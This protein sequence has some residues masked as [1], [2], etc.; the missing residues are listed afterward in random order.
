MYIAS[1]AAYFEG[2]VE[3]RNRDGQTDHRARGESPGDDS[4]KR[5]S[6]FV[7]LSSVTAERARRQN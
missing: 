2:R 1:Y 3:A 5:A 7:P 6:D 4:E